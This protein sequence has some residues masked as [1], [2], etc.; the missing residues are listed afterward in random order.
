MVAAGMVVAGACIDEEVPP[1]MAE[2]VVE[3]GLDSVG[4]AMETSSGT[5]VSTQSRDKVASSWAGEVGEAGVLGVTIR[6]SGC[7]APS[8]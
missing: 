5:S 2:E 6:Y 3:L 7:S 4:D 1:D 8:R